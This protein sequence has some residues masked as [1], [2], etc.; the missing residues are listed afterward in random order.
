MSLRHPERVL[1]LHFF[2]PVPLMRLV[3]VIR[4][5][6]TSNEVFQRGI[7]FVSSLG[8]V[9]VGSMKIFPAL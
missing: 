6:D 8:K 5:R 2:G 1:G 3:E 9:P 7:A 4:G